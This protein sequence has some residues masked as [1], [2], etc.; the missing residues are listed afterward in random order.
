MFVVDF[1]L[2]YSRNKRIVNEMGEFL[3]AKKCCGEKHN[4]P[5]GVLS[6]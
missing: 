4:Q 3:L 5:S 1:R 6:D 2:A